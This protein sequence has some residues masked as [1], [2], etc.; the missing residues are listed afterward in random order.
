[1]FYEAE[2]GRRRED[3][4]HCFGACIDQFP[5]RHL[6]GSRRNRAREESVRGLVVRDAAEGYVVDKTGE[7]GN[8]QQKTGGGPENPKEDNHDAPRRSPP[9]VRQSRKSC[10]NKLSPS[11]A[12]SGLQSALWVKYK[13]PSSCANNGL[14]YRA[15]W[16]MSFS[17][18]QIWSR[19]K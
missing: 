18:R 6:Q 7:S 1:M 5:T 10:Q 2:K 13:T 17:Q 16:C 8:G 4:E 9:A 14:L 15:Q 12:C 3:A 11:F 19:R